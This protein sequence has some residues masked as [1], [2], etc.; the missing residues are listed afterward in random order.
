M[1]GWSYVKNSKVVS[2]HPERFCHSASQSAFIILLR[3]SETLCWQG[4][5]HLAMSMLHLL[6]PFIIMKVVLTAFCQDSLAAAAASFYFY[7]IIK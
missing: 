4:F 6:H 5:S 3:V 2:I 7:V 1:I